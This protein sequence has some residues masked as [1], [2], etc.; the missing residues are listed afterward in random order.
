[1]L[2]RR[3]D[4]RGDVD[5]RTGVEAHVGVAGQRDGRTTIE[6]ALDEPPFARVLGVDAVDGAG[7]KQGNWQRRRKQPLLELDLGAGV[8]LRAGSNDAPRLPGGTVEDGQAERAGRLNAAA[9][10]VLVH[11]GRGD[12]GQVAIEIA[13]ANELVGIGPAKR[14]RVDQGV[15]ACPERRAQ[16]RG[17]LPVEGHEAGTRRHVLRRPPP[18]VCKSDVPVPPQQLGR[19][20]DADLSRT[21]DDEGGTGHVTPP[22]SNPAAD[23]R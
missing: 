13:Q 18:G 6:H 1:M 9:G 19:R 10:I 20:R 3:G 5:G 2:D 11:A 16:R 23:G 12:D 22:G 17:V 14:H 8:G 7:T 15:D 21:A 4:Q